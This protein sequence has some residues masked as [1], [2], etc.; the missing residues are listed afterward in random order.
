MNELDWNLGN[1]V[2]QYVATYIATLYHEMMEHGFNPNYGLAHKLMIW[3]RHPLR[4]VS[5]C[6][7]YPLLAPRFSCSLV[8][9]I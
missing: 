4:A 1:V 8:S 2:V 6:G 7:I 5:Q 3:H 9:C